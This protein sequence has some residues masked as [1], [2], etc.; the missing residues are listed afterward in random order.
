MVLLASRRLSRVR[1]YSGPLA[2]PVCLRVR[3]SHTL[4]SAL[5][6]RSPRQ[7]LPAWGRMPPLQMPSTPPAQR[8]PPLTCRRFGLVPLR[9]PLLRQSL[10]L[11]LPPGTEMFQFPDWPASLPQ[12]SGG[13]TRRGL[14]HSD[15]FGSMGARPSPKRFAARCVLPRPLAPRHPPCTLGSLLSLFALL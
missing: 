10:L 9:S 5:P 4:R 1:R 13:P 14:P 7:T 2:A 6:H 12:G 8:H 15:T 3:D 11:S